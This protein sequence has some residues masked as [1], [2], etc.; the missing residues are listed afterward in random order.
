MLFLDIAFR[1]ER[2]VLATE[3]PHLGSSCSCCARERPG[4]ALRRGARL[5]LRSGGSAKAEAAVIKSSMAPAATFSLKPASSPT[6]AMD[7]QVPRQPGMAAGQS[8][9]PPRVPHRAPRSSYG[10]VPSSAKLV[11]PPAYS[12]RGTPPARSSGWVG[13]PGSPENGRLALQAAGAAKGEAVAANDGS[14]KGT[15]AFGTPCGA[16]SREEKDGPARL[17]SQMHGSF[18]RGNSSSPATRDD[19]RPVEGEGQVA[20]APQRPRGSG[21]SCRAGPVVGFHG[22][23]KPGA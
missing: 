16:T 23:K 19:A 15:P 7:G 14:A 2:D 9:R 20:A 5:V 6:K 13:S 22:K 3:F 11:L 1:S 17:L 18:G 4:V 10:G 12:H 21:R 8:P